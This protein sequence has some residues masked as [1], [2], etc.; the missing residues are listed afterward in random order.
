[1]PRRIDHLGLL[2]GGLSPEHEAEAVAMIVQSA[3]GAVGELFPAVV[4][5]RVGLMRAH[6][7]DG[8]E[9]EHALPG[10]GA[11]I[12]VV[13]AG[14]AVFVVELAKDV[15]QRRRWFDAPAH[16]KAETVRLTF[17]VI[18]ILTQEHHFDLIKGRRPKSIKDFAAFGIHGVQFF[19]FDQEFF[20]LKHLLEAKLI[21]RIL[22][23]Q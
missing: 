9:H 19:F 8:V 21:R 15:H 12:A 10:P 11:Q 6:G 14:V 4:A 20:E 7:E 16:R 2:G 22:L 13:R 17:A 3:D 5:V 23:F 18:G 1:M